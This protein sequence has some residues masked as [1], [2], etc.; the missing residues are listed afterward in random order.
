MEKKGFTLT[1]KS[2]H[3]TRLERK[4]DRGHLVG[5]DSFSQDYWLAKEIKGFLHEDQKEQ[6]Q[7]CSGTRSDMKLGQ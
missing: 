4:R 1:R 5:A 3:I 2:Q 6:G 7:K